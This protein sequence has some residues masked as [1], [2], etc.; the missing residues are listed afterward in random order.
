MKDSLMKIAT[1]MLIAGITAAAKEGLT[2]LQSIEWK[3]SSDDEVI[4]TED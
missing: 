3:T 2:Q 1:A 4:S